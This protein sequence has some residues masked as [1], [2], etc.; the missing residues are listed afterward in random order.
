MKYLI[1]FD[2]SNNKRRAAVVRQCLASGYR[3]QK[4]VFEAFLEKEQVADFEESMHGL[5]NL[6]TDSVR[7]YPLDKVADENIRIV[8]CGRHIDQ[9]VYKII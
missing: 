4:S 8:G 9:S 2:I 7:I 1:A 6:D 5:I 3:V